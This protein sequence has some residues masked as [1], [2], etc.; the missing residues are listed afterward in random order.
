MYVCLLS[1]LTV[2]KRSIGH[3]E[4]L[5]GEQTEAVAEKKF[6]FLLSATCRVDLTYQANCEGLQ[7]SS[8]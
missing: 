6:L 7:K 5:F 3:L 4:N 2:A 8:P 1:I